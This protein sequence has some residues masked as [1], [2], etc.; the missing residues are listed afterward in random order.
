MDKAGYL[1]LVMA[2]A[3]VKAWKAT[4]DEKDEAI[5]ALI[6]P[7][8]DSVV[9]RHDFIWACG[10]HVESTVADQAEYT[11]KGKSD[12]CGDMINVKYGTKDLLLIKLLPTEADDK[13]SNITIPSAVTY[14]VHEGTSQGYPKIRLIG[15]PTSAGNDITYR[16]RRKEL[17]PQEVPEHMAGDMAN[18]ILSELFPESRNLAQAKERAILTMIRN[19]TKGGGE[20]RPA[21]KDKTWRANNRRRN[22]LYGY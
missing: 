11:L 9:N 22:Q 16:Y 1:A 21:P 14:W 18:V 19:D 13:F 15:T 3:E 7:T 17:K 8:I 5:N 12:Q 10:T 6:V 4:P 2:K 20:Q